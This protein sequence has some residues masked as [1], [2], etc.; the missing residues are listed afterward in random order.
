MV[1]GRTSIA[2]LHVP[3]VDGIGKKE[4]VFSDEM[5]SVSF[6]SCSSSSLADSPEPPPL[7]SFTRR[8]YSEGNS[9]ESALEGNEG[10][11]YECARID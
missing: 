8:R 9:F 7:D 10:Q 5:A 1:R 3:R 2:S 4:R 6:G 11:S